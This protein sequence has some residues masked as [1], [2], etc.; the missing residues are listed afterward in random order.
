MFAPKLQ[1]PQ[2]ISANSI[3]GKR[4]PEENNVTAC[5]KL[6]G[7]EGLAWMSHERG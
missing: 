4:L 6:S 2:V 7:L 3:P 5:G 1:L